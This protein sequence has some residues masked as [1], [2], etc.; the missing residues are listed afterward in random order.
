MNNLYLE[1]FYLYL[2]NQKRYSNHTIMAYKR[3]LN[4]FF[5]FVKKENITDLNFLN[6]QSYFSSLYLQEKSM[7]TISRKLSALKSY[8]KYLTSKYQINTNFLKMI[9]LP[10]KEK[11]L[12]VYLHDN[13]LKILLNLPKNNFLQIRNNLIINLLYS[14]GIRLSELTNLKLNDYN[15]NEN[16]FIVK[17]KGNK[18]RVVVFSSKCKEAIELYLKYRISNSD[19]L[20]VNKNN[21]KLTNR[22][23]ELILTNIS[24]KY[25]GHDKLH[26]HMLRHTYA[27]KLLNNG[28]DLRT[29]QELLG[30]DSLSATQVYTH[31]AK[32]E[33][34]ELYT[35][36]HPRGDNENL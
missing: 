28:M 24:K 18:Q 25:L 26:P 9:N 36:Y 17:G 4:L 23:V 32:N 7:K 6:V 20:L 30:H 11:K 21:T 2:S 13:E 29:L 33:L 19:Y 27:T 14:T 15:K 22:G 35:T 8:G 34:S 12:P 5:E 31:V 1:E 16:I 10:K 3:D